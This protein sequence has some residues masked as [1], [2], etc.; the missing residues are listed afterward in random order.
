M[1]NNLRALEKLIA[2]NV[3]RVLVGVDNPV[4]HRRPDFAKHLDHLPG[5]GEIRLCV[6]DH[7]ATDVDKPGISVTNPVLFV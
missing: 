6:D 2:K 7:A 5:M 3:I 1:T 4:G